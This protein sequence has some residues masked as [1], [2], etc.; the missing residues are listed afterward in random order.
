MSRPTSIESL[1]PT[2][3]AAHPSPAAERLMNDTS[4]IVD[5]LAER[6]GNGG[7]LLL[8]ADYDGTLTPI[9]ED[10]DEA[11]L[12]E[13]VR[14][15]LRVLARSPR[16]HLA[17]VSGRDV[18]DLRERVGVSEAICAGCHGLDIEGPGLRFCHP[19]AEAQQHALGAITRELILRAP[20]LPGMRVEAKRFGLAVHYR[21]V[22]PDQVRRVEIELA[23]ALKQDGSRLRIFQGSKA[24]EIQPQ[25]AWSKGDGLLWIR[26]TL[27]RAV[28]ARMTALYMGDDWTDEKAFEVLG[29]QAVTVRIGN[30]VPASSA[31]HRLPDVTAVHHLLAALADRVVAGNGR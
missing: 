14:D 4:R 20:T 26:D 11:R 28:S 22:A 7:H 13:A 5:G 25:V 27:A 12:P 15:H 30:D 19:E 18:A 10:P 1:D 2:S 23:R 8:L 24:I 3:R 6:L 16:V 31:S 21:H 9:V 29:S 17:V